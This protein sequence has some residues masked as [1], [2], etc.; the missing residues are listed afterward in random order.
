M[1]TNVE[2][3]RR[4]FQV[5]ASRDHAGNLPSMTESIPTIRLRSC[6]TAAAGENARPA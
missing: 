3:I 1:T 5:D 6:A 2:A 4:L